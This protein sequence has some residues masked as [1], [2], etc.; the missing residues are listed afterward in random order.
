M[1]RWLPAV[2]ILLIL[3]TAG[4]QCTTRPASADDATLS[5][6]SIT[7]MSPAPNSTISKATPVISARFVSDSP[8]DQSS[9][10]LFIDGH[11]VT[12][13]EETSINATGI[14]Y[15]VPAIEGQALGAGNHTVKV[16]ASDISGNPTMR[17]WQFTVDFNA[18]SSA[19]GL[20]IDVGQ[21]LQYVILGA[22][23]FAAGFG[24]Y[25]AYLKKTRKFTFR[26]YFARNPVQRKYLVVYLPLIAAFV[27]AVLAMLLVSEG[28]WS[29]PFA[30]EIVL[31]IAM[32]IAG[33]PY[34]LNAQMERRKR[35]KYES[36]YAQFLFEM[37]DAIRGGMDPAK[38][39][40]EYSK[41][42]KGILKKPL[43]IA[44]DGIMMGRPFEEVMQVMVKPMDSE[45]IHRYASL[46]GE[47]A[48]VGGDISIV[49]HRAAKDMDDLIK[50]ENERRRQLGFQATT[51]YISFAVL[52]IVVWQLISIYPSLGNIN[53][54]LL[55]VTSPMQQSS[56]A[57]SATRMSFVTLKHRFFQLI[58]VSSVA[59]GLLIGAFT[60]GKPKMGILHALIM[61]A[62]ATAFFAIFIF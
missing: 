34:A 28:A 16:V 53:I 6:P 26:K 7:D 35:N 23:A 30:Y 17:E 4:A 13:F 19:G 40:V 62:A 3:L 32:F 60:E 9:V 58:L 43:K 59:S 36:A 12:D 31:V 29:S 47:A 50:I 5:P 22:L 11:D 1:R 10:R 27:F 25:I 2:A 37:A 51:M 39:V 61:V 42:H 18:A 57:E 33:G 14:S 24:L 49:I 55:G 38:A 54:S 15:H 8:I 41:V 56:I 20:K 48:K 45:L 21:I 52:I 46:I 44:S